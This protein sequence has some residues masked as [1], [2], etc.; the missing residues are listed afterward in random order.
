MV[1]DDENL[2]LLIVKEGVIECLRNYW[3]SCPP[4]RSLEVAVELLRGLASSQAIAEG[5]VSDGF[6][7][8]LVAVLNLGVLGVR[9][10]VAR[11][12]SELSCNTKTRKEIGDLCPVCLLES[13]L[14][15]ESEFRGK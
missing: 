11:A 14:L 5:L 7:V 13:G 6:V 9:I 2:K 4:V 10:A 1:K 8:R 3:D 15:L 12:V